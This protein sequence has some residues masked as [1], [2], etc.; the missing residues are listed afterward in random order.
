MIPQIVALKACTHSPYSFWRGEHTDLFIVL[1]GQLNVPFHP[2]FSLAFAKD[3]G[4]GKAGRLFTRLFF[5]MSLALLVSRLR[6]VW[7]E[8]RSAREG[9]CAKDTL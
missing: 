4:T 1:K 8:S 9:R 7:C 5:P 3:C 6:L 2:D